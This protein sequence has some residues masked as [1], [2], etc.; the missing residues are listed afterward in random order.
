MRAT[1]EGQVLQVNVSNPSMRSISLLQNGV[2]SRPEVVGVLFG[3]K[4]RT[5]IPKVGDRSTMEVSVFLGKK[6]GLLVFAV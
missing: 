6:G 2:G 3:E 4:A 5:A 1:I